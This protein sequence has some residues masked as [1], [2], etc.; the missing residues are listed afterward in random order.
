MMSSTHASQ[1]PCRAGVG[2]SLIGL[3]RLMTMAFQG[4]DLGPLAQ[5]LIER[6]SA[7]GQD[8][9]ALMDLSTIL[10]LQGHKDLG[11]ATQALALQARRL[12]ELPAGRTPALRL[13]AIMAPGD[14]MT[15]APL[16]FLIEDSDVALSMLY[17]QPGE[18]VPEALPAHDVAF[19]AVSESGPTRGLLDQLARAVPSWRRPVI[20]RPDRILRTS[21][22]QACEVLK[23]AP[24]ICMPAT[25]RASRDELQRL[26]L[27]EL[28]LGAV[29]PG[30]AFPLIVRPVDSHAGDGLEKVDAAQDIPKYLEATA[31]GEFF[32]S[33]FV[34][35]RGEDGLFRKYRV[36]LVDGVAFAGHMG[37][38]AHW[39]IHYLNA[40]M[41]ESAGKRA[42]E[43]RFM[44]RFEV[45]FA[46]RHAV[47]LRAIAERF[48]LDYLVIDCGESADGDLL[49]FEVD[50]GAVVHSMDPPDL[51][52]YKPA[53]MRKVFEAFRGMLMRAGCV[54][55]DNG[56]H[57][58]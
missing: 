4:V 22:A 41:T 8:A 40:G 46:R 7:D 32:I 54:A 34:D 55:I 37:V 43:E 10:H 44:G 15:N 17:L 35:Y 57:D 42:E 45:D 5:A 14:L 47:A 30:C 28:D 26:S 39:M 56:G 18:P 50:P 52:P 51:F 20:N 2:P 29:L 33:R 3:A 49:V 48:G 19:I 38:S 6:V 12:F 21:R 27:G 16:P 53:A 58:R 25:V 1:P 36:V 23:G 24:G 13:L 31:G 9:D 11:L